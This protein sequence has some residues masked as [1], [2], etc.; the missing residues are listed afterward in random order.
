MF[1]DFDYVALGHLHG[2]QN[3][4]NEKIRY[5]GTPLKYSFSEVN[6]EKSVSV[7]ELGEKGSLSLNTVPL[8]PLHDMVEFRGTYSELMENSFYKDTSYD[9][10]Y[11][12]ITLTDEEDVMFAVTRLRYIYKNL[13]K[14]DYDNKRTR[15]KALISGTEDIE[16]KTPLELFAELYV[17]QNGA[18]MT[19]EQVKFMNEIINKVWEGEQ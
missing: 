7:V 2:P 12:H 18:E 17:K 15:H 19:E 13:M 14:L 6:H 4:D 1:E 10:D 11:L 16:T 9:S 3:I 8:V 5:C